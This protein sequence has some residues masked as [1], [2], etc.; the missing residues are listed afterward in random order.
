MTAFLLVQTFYWLA[1]S[2]WFGGILFVA[3]AAPVIMQVTRDAEPLL[4]KVLSVNLEN[5]HGSLLAGEIVG[6]ILRKMASI[7]IGCAA[8][9]L[10]TLILQWFVMDIST[11]NKFHGVLRICFFVGAVAVHFYDRFVIWPK[12]W[13][14]RQEYLD[15]ADEPEVANPARE[16]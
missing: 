3:I 4:P 16:Q 10:I 1:L 12:V 8:I 9:L 5:Q 2:T 14:H 7:Q 15:H 11:T 6:S 13:R